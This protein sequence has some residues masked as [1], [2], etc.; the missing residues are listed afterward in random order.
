MKNKRMANWTR[1]CAS[2]VDE[3]G[4]IVFQH[5]FAVENSS[6]FFLPEFGGDSIEE[7]L[8]PGK[9]NVRAECSRRDKR[10]SF[11]SFSFRR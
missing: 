2:F 5:R 8:T 4:M 3:R 10:Q 11:P 9:K 1:K 6:N 7:K